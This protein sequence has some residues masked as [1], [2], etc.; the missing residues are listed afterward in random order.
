MNKE[1]AEKVYADFQYLIGTTSTYLPHNP[2]ITHLTIDKDLVGG[3][4]VRVYGQHP[5]S[6]NEWN[7]FIQTYCRKEGIKY[8]FP[9]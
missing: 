8:D 3:Y 6:P 7:E 2:T 9:S 4:H 5:S 1:Q